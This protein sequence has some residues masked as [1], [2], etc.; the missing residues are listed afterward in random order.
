ML[1]LQYEKRKGQEKDKTPLSL[2][3]EWQQSKVLWIPFH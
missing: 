3:M 2:I 1:S